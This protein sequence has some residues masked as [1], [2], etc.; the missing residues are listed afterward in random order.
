MWILKQHCDQKNIRMASVNGSKTETLG[1]YVN[2]ILEM[3]NCIIEAMSWFLPIL[4]KP[5]NQKV[6]F[7]TKRKEARFHLSW[8]YHTE[9]EGREMKTI[10]SS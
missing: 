4:N 1:L 9:S 3:F 7:S 10:K 5:H 8:H 2:C 6:I